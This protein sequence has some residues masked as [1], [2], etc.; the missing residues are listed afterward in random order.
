MPLSGNKAKILLRVL[1]D[2]VRNALLG[3]REGVLRVRVKAS[4]EKGRANQE[5]VSFLSQILSL[6]RGALTIIKGHTSRDKVIAID[7][8]SQDE[9]MR[10]LSSCGDAGTSKSR[11]R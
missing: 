1:P 3:F 5:L 8:L 9:V 10:R 6:P 2:A 4:P 11:R 7:G